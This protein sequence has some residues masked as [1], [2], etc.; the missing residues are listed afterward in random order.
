VTVQQKKTLLYCGIYLAVIWILAS[1]PLA[2]VLYEFGDIA[3]CRSISLG[4]F[5]ATFYGSF[6]IHPFFIGGFAAAALYLP[7][8]TAVSLVRKSKTVAL[9]LLAFYVCTT[10][11]IAYVEFSHSPHAVF[12]IAPNVL[13]AHH[14]VLNGL[15]AACNGQPY[16]SYETDLNALISEGRSY[17]E[18][19]YYVGFVAQ[20]LLQNAIFVVFLVFIYY[21]KQLIVRTAVY[22]KD[23]IF[24]LLGYAVFLSSIWCL[25][26][27]TYRHEGNLLFGMDNAQRGDY[28]I[29]YL[30]GIVLMVFVVYFEFNLETIAKTFSTIGQFLFFVGGVAALELKKE[31]ANWFFG[32]QASVVNIFILCLLFAFMTAL[33]LAFILKPA[34]RRA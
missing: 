3:L 4:W 12:E 34:D 22:V 10:V 9:V 8:A 31:Q 16:L 32:S 29:V 7:F 6:F 1:L 33:A 5:A 23:S 30:Y 26:R 18:W 2:F 28:A 14:N 21:D 13:N 19:A 25:F 27:L 15:K 17:T 20:A 24:F 11:A